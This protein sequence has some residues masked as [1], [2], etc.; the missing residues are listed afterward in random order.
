M[1]FSRPFL[2]GQGINLSSHFFP[3]DGKQKIGIL[4]SPGGETDAS[5][6]SK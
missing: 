5:K 2:L 4:Q 6:K 1:W 3:M